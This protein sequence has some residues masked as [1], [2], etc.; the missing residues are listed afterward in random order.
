[1]IHDLVRRIVILDFEAS[2]LPQSGRSYPIEVGA[3]I[4]ETGEVRCWLIRPER[5]WL[6]AWDWHD[7]SEQIHGLT[8]AYLLAHGLPREQVG[9]ELMAFIGHR[10]LV[11]DNPRAEAAWLA[12]LLDEE[13]LRPIAWLSLLYEALTAGRKGG[14]EAYQ[15]AETHA[16][17]MA[18]PTHRA[19]GDVR[20]ELVKLRALLRL[21]DDAGEK[22]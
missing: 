15:Q 22:S 16:Y 5:Q 21:M 12:V 7:E 20:H 19:G 13:R 11:S 17:S 8:R 9:D 4:V 10:E 2:C 1:M 3:G 14:H 6:K 18:P